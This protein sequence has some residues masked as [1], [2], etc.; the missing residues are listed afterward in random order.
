MNDGKKNGRQ[1]IINYREKKRNRCE[2]L[3]IKNAGNRIK[4]SNEMSIR[5]N[6]YNFFLYLQLRGQFVRVAHFEVCSVSIW[7][8]AV[9]LAFFTLCLSLSFSPSPSL[10]SC[11]LQTH[12]TGVEARTYFENQIVEIVC[13]AFWSSWCNTNITL[14]AA[15]SCQTVSSYQFTLFFRSRSLFFSFINSSCFSHLLSYSTVTP[16]CKLPS[17]W[18]YVSL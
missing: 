18:A 8:C 17:K 10:S 7:E 13:K 14:M 11:F 3:S 4:M 12:L 9:V 6:K 1:F 2:S 16:F 5:I 15:A